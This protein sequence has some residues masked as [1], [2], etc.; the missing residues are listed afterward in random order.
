MPG[1]FDVPG[2]VQNYLFFVVREVFDTRGIVAVVNA[3]FVYKCKH[4]EKIW[5]TGFGLMNLGDG[6]NFGVSQNEASEIVHVLDKS[7]PA[8]QTKFCN[9][10]RLFGVSYELFWEFADIWP[11]TLSLGSQSPDVLG[12]FI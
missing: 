4:I 3:K 8:I 12:Y 2:G 10:V 11:W 6:V 1:D 9:H 7:W 5:V